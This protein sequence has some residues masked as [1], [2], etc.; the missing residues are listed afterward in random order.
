MPCITLSDKRKIHLF[1]FIQKDTP[2]A[3]SFRSWELYEYP[4]LPSTVNHV[5]TVKTSNQLDKP[6]F[7]ILAFHAKKR[8]ERTI[9][10]SH[11]DHCNIS[12]VKLFLNSQYYPYGNL[13]LDVAHNQYALLYDMHIF[14]VY[15]ILTKQ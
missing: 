2:I 5:W 10:A 9:N 4:M 13:N 7:V 12:N 6:R 15:I 14:K 1:N 11:F 8:G 3:V